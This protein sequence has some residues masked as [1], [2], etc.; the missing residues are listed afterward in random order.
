M[1]CTNYPIRQTPHAI[2]LHDIRHTIY[3]I[4]IQNITLTVI[5]ITIVRA[6]VKISVFLI[7]SSL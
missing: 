3:D 5:V 7:F 4:R 2:F 1:L 6:K